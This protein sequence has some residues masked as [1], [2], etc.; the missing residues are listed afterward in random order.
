[1]FYIFTSIRFEP[2][3]TS[4]RNERYTAYLYLPY[5]VY[6]LRDA[7]REFSFRILEERLRDDATALEYLKDAVDAAVPDN[8]VP[9]R[10][11][12]AFDKDGTVYSTITQL[13]SQDGF[14]WT[15]PE[16]EEIL[17]QKEP[18]P[19]K[20]S[21]YAEYLLQ[22]KNRLPIPVFDVFVDSQPATASVYTRHKTAV[23]QMY[24]DSRAR[25]GLESYEEPEEVLLWN[26]D[27]LLMEGSIST[28][29]VWRHQG[30]GGGAG[31]YLA[32]PPLSSGPNAGATRRYALEKGLCVEEDIKVQE[33]RDGEEIWLS[34]A[35]Y[36]FFP[37]RI[38]LG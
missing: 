8:N 6:R 17:E 15:L 9:W 36:G 16:P 4:S 13:P 26:K 29:F 2:S 38:R 25:A 5:H 10:A 21:I 18:L 31:I 23:R 37:G 33:L 22:A 34:H 20:A 3:L 24:T 12:L 1:P 35:T 19:S 11:R 30:N 32:T 27:G 14:V 28:V 7:A